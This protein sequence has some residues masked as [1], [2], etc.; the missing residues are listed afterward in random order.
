MMFL[1]CQIILLLC[2]NG[3]L[4]LEKNGRLSKRNV[5]SFFPGKKEYPRNIISDYKILL[6]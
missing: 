6:N 5:L 3:L 1:F 2:L 4:W